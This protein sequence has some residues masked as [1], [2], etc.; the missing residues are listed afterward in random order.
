MDGIKTLGRSLL[1]ILQTRLEL[2]GTEIAEERARIAEILIY[3][4]ATFIAV[5]LA[6]L[7][8]AAWA[9]AAAWESSHRGLILGLA[10]M[11]LFVVAALCMAVA[12]KKI[13][14]HGRMFAVSVDQLK[15]D[16]SSLK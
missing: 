12:L 1:T 15:L 2:L 4:A 9:I 8:V 10:T 5:F 14:R 6:T 3:L 7:F 11:A 13:D 16:I